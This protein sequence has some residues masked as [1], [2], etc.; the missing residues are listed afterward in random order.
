M[1]VKEPLKR[2]EVLTDKAKVKAPFLSD[3]SSDG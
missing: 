1:D 2:V 3:R